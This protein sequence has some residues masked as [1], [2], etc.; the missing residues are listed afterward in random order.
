MKRFFSFSLGAIAILGLVLA[1]EQRALAYIDPGSGLIVLQS[2]GSA[3]A[4]AAYF[5]RRRI[6]SFFK[7]SKSGK[8]STNVT[9]ELESDRKTA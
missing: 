9:V 2:I 1:T 3:I 5:M 7:R 8:A 6:F 4:A